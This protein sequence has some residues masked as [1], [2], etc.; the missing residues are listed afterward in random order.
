MPCQTG[1]SPWHL[2]GASEKDRLCDA[3]INHL[4]LGECQ[5]TNAVLCASIHSILPL[6][7]EPNTLHNL[8]PLVLDAVIKLCTKKTLRHALS[9]I[10]ITYD[11][12]GNVSGLRSLLSQYCDTLFVGELPHLQR[13]EHPSTALRDIADNWPQQTSHSDKAWIVHDFCTVTSS[14]E[15][16]TLTCA[17]CAER[18]CANN[19]SKRLVSDPDLNVL[20][21]PLFDSSDQTDVAP[22]LPLM[23]PQ[24]WRGSPASLQLSQSPYSCPFFA[25]PSRCSPLKFFVPGASLLL[26]ELPRLPRSFTVFCGVPQSSPEF[27]SLCRSSSLSAGVAATSSEPLSLGVLWR[28]FAK[29]PL[30]SESFLVVSYD[31]A[32]AS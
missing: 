26:L 27:S 12:V 2:L 23:C 8:R 18:V 9:C 15:L 19:V 29:L 10:G 20:R 4:V 28:F 14:S 16:K 30:S 31:A 5:N 24:S 1:F 7:H 13:N 17:S 32:I 21:N 22:P 11:P 25:L 3:I 6:T